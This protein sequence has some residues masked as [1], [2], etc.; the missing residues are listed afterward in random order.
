MPKGADLCILAILPCIGVHVRNLQ[1]LCFL[2]ATM[3][4]A[5]PTFAQALCGNGVLDG[6]E[7][8]DDQNAAEGCTDCLVDTGFTCDNAA[9]T[10][11]I[12]NSGF[13]NG[14]VGWTADIPVYTIDVAQDGSLSVVA[15]PNPYVTNECVFG[16]CLDGNG[17]GTVWRQ[18]VTVLP[19][20][21]YT[22]S[23]FVA[24]RSDGDASSILTL[25]V[26][27]VDVTPA[28][29]QLSSAPAPWGVLSATFVATAAQ[30]ELSVYNAYAGGPGNGFAMDELSLVRGPSVC[31][32]LP[33][34]DMGTGESDAGFDMSAQTDM[35]AELDMAAERDMAVER[36]MA[37]ADSST[38]P[39]PNLNSGGN[40]D[41]G[42]GCGS[43]GKGYDGSVVLMLLGFLVIRRRR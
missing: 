36:D 23:A 39:T 3:L 28:F 34:E 41:N 2:T 1:V 19:G 31:V 32:A 13:E 33:G 42:C 8:C 15:A 29:D 7:A 22:F 24:V 26:D 43:T 11:L 25:R 14:T 4:Y 9:S 27:G 30:V 20:T 5:L 6:A 16:S 17:G 38:V 10:N 37:E 12:T 18:T 35:A 40:A 21:S